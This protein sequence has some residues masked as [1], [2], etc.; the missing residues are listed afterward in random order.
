M[1]IILCTSTIQ[2][3]CTCVHLNYIIHTQLYMAASRIH[4]RHTC[5]HLQYIRNTLV[6]I[7]ITLET[8]LCE[9]TTHRKHICVHLQATCMCPSNLHQSDIYVVVVVHLY[10]MVLENLVFSYN[11]SLQTLSTITMKNAIVVT[12]IIIFMDLT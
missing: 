4:Q 3:S 8:H 6:C 5:M 12:C 11:L 1:L 9:S 2:Y 10:F 7:Y